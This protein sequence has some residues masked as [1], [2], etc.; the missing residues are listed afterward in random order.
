LL[1]GDDGE[2]SFKRRLKEELDELESKPLIDYE[3]W[4]NVFKDSD[5]D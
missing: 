2:D 5:D 3:Y 1:S 4:N